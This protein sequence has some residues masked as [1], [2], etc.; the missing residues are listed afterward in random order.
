MSWTCYTHINC[1]SVELD[2]LPGQEP[3]KGNTPA[4]FPYTAADIAELEIYVLEEMD[5]YMMLQHPYD[6]LTRQVFS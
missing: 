3:A 1:E 4:R 2:P 5:F 6:L